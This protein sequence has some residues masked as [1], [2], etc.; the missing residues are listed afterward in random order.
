MVKY[1]LVELC[2]VGSSPISRVVVL[3]IY[4]SCF[5]RE[6]FRCISIL[7]ILQMI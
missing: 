6:Y 4:G 7:I 3:G 5:L 2:D 1:Q